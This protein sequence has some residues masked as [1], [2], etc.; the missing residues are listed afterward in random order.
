MVHGGSTDTDSQG[1]AGYVQSIPKTLYPRACAPRRWGGHQRRTAEH[2]SVPGSD[3]SSGYGGILRL[4]KELTHHSASEALRKGAN[5]VLAP[6]V[7]V[8]R[9]PLD[10]RDYESLGEDPFSGRTDGRS[11]DQWHTEQ[12]GHHDGEAFCRL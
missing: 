1:A 11:R 12:S 8:D 6:D 3:R 2:H 5:V 9:V 7:N 4:E 10:G